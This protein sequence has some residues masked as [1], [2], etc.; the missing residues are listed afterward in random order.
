M[1]ST[2][3]KVHN[4]AQRRRRRAETRPLATFTKILLRS[5]V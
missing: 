1:P 4:V 5:R 3:P 2:K